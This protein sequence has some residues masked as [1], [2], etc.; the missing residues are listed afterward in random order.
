MKKVFTLL[1]AFSLMLSSFA[2]LTETKRFIEPE[3]VKPHLKQVT[4]KNNF[5]KNFKSAANRSQT[6]A[7]PID[8]G[9]ADIIYADQKS[10]TERL[11]TFEMNT[12]YKNT[13]NLTLRYMAVLFDSLIDADFNA[14]LINHYPRKLSTVTLDS[15]D[16]VFIHTNTTGNNDSI[17]FI[18]FDRDSVRIVGTGANASLE[19][20]KVWDTV[21]V[22]NTSLP[23]N[24]TVSGT[25]T[26]TAFTTYPNKTF[27]KGK[28]FGVRV[29]FAGDTANKFQPLSFFRDDCGQACIAAPTAAGFNSLYYINYQ[30]PTQGNISGINNLAADCNQNGRTDP[31]NCEE[32]YVQNWWVVPAVTL[33]VDYGAVISS[34]SLRGCPGEP[35]NLTANVYGSTPPYTY[36]WSTSSGT[37]TGNQ[38][39]NTTL[40]LGNTPGQ[41]T[42]T[43][44]VSSTDGTTSS[45]YVISN[46]AINMTIVNT[47]P[48]VRTCNESATTVITQT[49]GNQTGRT[50]LWNTGA[51][52]PTLAVSEQGLYTVTVTNSSNCKATASIN[53]NYAGNISNNVNFTVPARICQ[54]QQATFV[55]TSSGKGGAWSSTWDMF[56]NGGSLVFNEDAVFT[57]SNPGNYTVKLT[58]DTLNG[59]KFSN[60][61]LIT[62]LP[63]AN[64]QC[65]NGISD[66]S[67]EN[68]ITMMP[69]PT[70]GSLNILVNGVEKNI[71]IRVYNIIGS[72]V[73][74][75]NN[76]D[77]PSVFNRTFDFSDLSNGTYLVRVESGNR[78]AIKKLIINH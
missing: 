19:N 65:V 59:C 6:V 39:E 78:T 15:L 64:P 66:V 70:N 13:D 55:N 10:T 68:A 37:L 77:V 43:L 18:V 71:S 61:K 46:N 29:E 34:D 32:F 5:I 45:S 60:T 54:N 48:I 72:E 38:G 36:N 30:H 63:A 20:N 4:A 12:R 7:F 67:F 73:K 62:V 42:V 40:I 57:Y 21:I 31:E 22:T 26:Y 53:V 58:M 3:L 56:N 41:V 23:K 35:I 9:L 2:Q 47:N 69:N 8:Y 24:I 50:F 49:T 51:T 74:S 33:N 44:D 76:N 17:R 27:A 11:I 14:K 1:C 28:T 75:F 16:V 25:P 52:T